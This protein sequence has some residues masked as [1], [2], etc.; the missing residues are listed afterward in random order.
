MYGVKPLERGYIVTA[1]GMVKTSIDMAHRFMV[2]TPTSNNSSWKNVLSENGSVISEY[3]LN[4]ADRFSNLE[5]AQEE[6]DILRIT[7]WREN[8]SQEFT[9]IGVFKIDLEATTVSGVCIY[10]R[11]SDLL[12]AIPYND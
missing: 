3:P 10:R 2:W 8:P 9:F 1:G 5:S 12:P 6:Q 11:V 4:E 7:F